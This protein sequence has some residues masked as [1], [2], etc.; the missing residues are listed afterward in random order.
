MLQMVNLNDAYYIGKVLE[1]D[2][3]AFSYLVNR[4]SEMV[5]SI[6]FKLLQ[7]AS[8]AEDLAQEV[9]ISAYQ[10][11]KNY[12]GS[13]KF[14]TWLYRITFNKA[15]SKL[16][17]VKHEIPTDNEKHLEKSGGSDPDSYR[18]QVQELSDEEEKV[19]VL[20]KVISQ[21]PDDDQLLIM[22]HYYDNQSIEDISNITG[23]SA[24]NVK[25]KLYRIRKKLK[26]MIEL[27]DKRILLFID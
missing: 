12:R 3:A 5:Y 7:N 10:S 23:L 27:I 4:Y 13:S 24:S 20:E 18:G 17:K 9:F 6:A 16:R 22:L 14:S 15:I 11:L 26:E 19:K 2:K 25:V 1:G 21:L 8:D